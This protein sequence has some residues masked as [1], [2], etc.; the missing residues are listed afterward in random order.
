VRVIDD[1]RGIP[2]DMH[3]SEGKPAVEVVLTVLHAGGKF[4]GSGYSGVR[5]PAR[6][7]RVGG[8]RPVD[9]LDIEVRRKDGYDWQSFLTRRADGS[10]RKG[11]VADHTG[12][13]TITFWADA[14]IFET[15]H[16]DFETLSPA[17]SR[18][19]PS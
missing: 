1:G 8:Q 16:Y 7:R 6:R 13:T 14:D 18:R 3:A 17:G 12:T 4:G 11:E 15:T 5:R 19:W 10:L 9:P 2:V